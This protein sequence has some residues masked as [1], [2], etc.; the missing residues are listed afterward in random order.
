MRILVIG[1]GGHG[2]VVADILLRMKDA[3]SELSV[4]GY[5]DDDSSLVGQQF[6]GVRV[7]GRVADRASVPHDA[8]V[9]AVGG[10]RTRQRLAA[11]LAG[12]GERFAV[13]CHPKAI[14]APG[15]VIGPGSM[16]CAGVVINPGSVVGAHVILNTACTVD[17][18]NRI[19]DH[20]HIAP[21][22]HLGGDVRVGEGT[23]VGIGSSVLPQRSVGDWTVVGAGSVVNRDLPS[24]V[25]A[26]GI[27]ARTR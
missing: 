2:Q 5:L 7:M 27:P 20:A 18:H 16:V 22:V 24:N 9:V 19:G 8:V 4:V 13:A 6:L 15:V 26:F 21:G 1:A 14:I 25:T 12:Q 10:N 11:D 3:G 23:L 17:H